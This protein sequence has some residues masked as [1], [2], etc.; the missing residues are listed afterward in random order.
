[1]A[2]HRGSWHSY[3]L[4]RDGQRGTAVVLSEHWG[5]HNAVNYE[6]V[7]NGTRYTGAGHRNWHE[8]KDGSVQPG[9]KSVVYYSASHPWLSAL[10]MPRSAVEGFPVAIVACCF[11]LFGL[12]MILRTRQPSAPLRA[13]IGR[14][15]IYLRRGV[16]LSMSRP[17]RFTIHIAV[18]ALVIANS[19]LA[20][21]AAH[22]W[23]N[24]C[25]L[26]DG[27]QAAA[28]ITD[29]HWGGRDE[30][31]YEYV[32]DQIRYSR[33]TPR[34]WLAKKYGSVHPG[35]RIDVF[36]STSRPWQSLLEKPAGIIAEWPSL[37]LL[38]AIDFVA[39]AYLLKGL[40]RRGLESALMAL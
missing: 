12:A 5:G 19:L 23:T 21:F 2:L 9:Q 6:Y 4:L 28:Q 20:F 31:V 8:E 32:V 35:S 38:L 29:Q 22:C 27:K 10:D 18:I 24:Y 15:V 14:G 36:Y 3:W 7:V 25:V 33:A 40:R 39:I 26:A 11:L 16:G 34:D 37:L 1:M 17:R 30:V 13:E